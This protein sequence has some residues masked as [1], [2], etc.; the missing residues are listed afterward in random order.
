MVSESEESGAAQWD[1]SGSGC[2]TRFQSIH[3]SGMQS[4]DSSAKAEVHFQ[5]GS[6]TWLSAGGL[7]SS[8]CGPLHWSAHDAVA[9]LPQQQK[10]TETEAMQCLMTWAQQ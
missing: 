4:F 6:L 8:L 3:W 1:G 2:L 10:E 7:S 5:D 9:G